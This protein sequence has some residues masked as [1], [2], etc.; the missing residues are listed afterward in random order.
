MNTAFA[1]LQTQALGAV[2]AIEQACYSHPWSAQ[3]FADS[4]QAGYR[5]QGLW[6]GDEL[7]AYSVVMRGVEEA[8]LLNLSVARSSQGQGVGTRMLHELCTWSLQ[9]GLGWLWL[10]VRASNQRAL[11]LYERMG[12]ARVGLRK[13]YYPLTRTAQEDAVVMSAEIAQLLAA[14]E[15]A[16]A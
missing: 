12:L 11:A 8:H 9:A 14:S 4:M 13:G 10:E 3:N 7:Q 16:P 6:R 1:P 15:G 5:L 2:L